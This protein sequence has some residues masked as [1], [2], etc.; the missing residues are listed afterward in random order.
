MEDPIIITKMARAVGERIIRQ[1]KVYS[2]DAILA[3]VFILGIK[4]NEILEIKEGVYLLSSVWRN[5]K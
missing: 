1:I 3:N 2:K 4:R 5:R